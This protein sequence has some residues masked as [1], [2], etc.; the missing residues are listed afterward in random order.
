MRFRE[1]GGAWRGS[2]LEAQEGGWAR[3]VDE[4]VG[5]SYLLLNIVKENERLDGML[6]SAIVLVGF[7]CSQS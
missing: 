3:A 5:A 4:D 1:A 7:P 6:F 2:R